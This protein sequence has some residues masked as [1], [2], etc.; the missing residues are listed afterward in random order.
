SA[1]AQRTAIAQPFRA[2][3]VRRAAA[4]KKEGPR[5]RRGPLILHEGI[6]RAQNVSRTP[7]RIARGSVNDVGKVLSRPAFRKSGFGAVAGGFAIEPTGSV[8]FGLA[9]RP[10]SPLQMFAGTP[11]HG[12]LCARL[13]R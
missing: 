1:A 6:E 12:P 9:S 10:P 5:R 13:Y 2:P 7:N 3:W 8:L 4:I 11:P